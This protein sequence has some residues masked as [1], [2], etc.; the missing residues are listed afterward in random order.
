MQLRFKKRMML[1][2]I[3]IVAFAVGSHGLG[4]DP[5]VEDANAYVDSVLEFELPSRAG[6]FDP[7]TTHGFQP[8]NGHHLNGPSVRFV[9]FSVT[10]LRDVRRDGDCQLIRAQDEQPTTLKCDLSTELSYVAVVNM[11]FGNTT[12]HNVRLNGTFHGVKGPLTV[13]FR[14]SLPEKV[15]YVPR[16]EYMVDNVAW[17]QVRPHWYDVIQREFYLA[18][19]HVFEFATNKVFAQQ[20]FYAAK[21]VPFP[22]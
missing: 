16:Y 15:E 3:F 18:M 8:M 20:M 22:E 4:Y 11:T 13:I 5:D 21:G 7:L 17:Q 9:S 2:A 6:I 10:G 12:M 1:A 19:I 14:R